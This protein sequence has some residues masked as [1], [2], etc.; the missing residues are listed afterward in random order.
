MK[1]PAA[2]G[3]DV[4]VLPGFVPLKAL[5][6]GEAPLYPSEPAAR[7]A[8]HTMRRELAE[9]HAVALHRR[10]TYVHAERFAAVVERRAL[11][12]FREGAAWA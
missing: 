7:W 11:A 5:W 1:L 9:A 6:S 4:A 10:R 12:Q 2:E 8:V 3:A